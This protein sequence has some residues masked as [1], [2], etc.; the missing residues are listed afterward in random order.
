MNVLWGLYDLCG[1]NL[2]PL[3]PEE[4][5][6][7]QDNEDEDFNLNWRQQ[8][9]VKQVYLKLGMIKSVTK[10]PMFIAILRYS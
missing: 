7:D 10:S 2:L 5:N 9:K 8:K 6:S 4:D 3:C 1:P